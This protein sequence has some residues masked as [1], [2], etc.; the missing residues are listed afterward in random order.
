ML[1]PDVLVR[2][3]RSAVVVTVGGVKLAIRHPA[4]FLA[5][6]I[7]KFA[8]WASW[9][10]VWCVEVCAV[11]TIVE[12]LRVLALGVAMAIPDPADLASIGTF[13]A[14]VVIELAGVGLAGLLARAVPNLGPVA[15]LVTLVSSRA[16]ISVELAGIY[17]AV[18]VA[19]LVAHPGPHA[20]WSAVHSIGVSAVA[21]IM[22]ALVHVALYIAVSVPE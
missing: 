14:I 1:V 18:L 15:T 22:V 12:A 16:V 9:S 4:F 21:V 7:V 5:D 10:T 2:A 3:L 17:I 20:L 8:Y 19:L 13:F 11:V 6:P